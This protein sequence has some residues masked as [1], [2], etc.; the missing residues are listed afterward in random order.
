MSH[1][2]PDNCCN[3]FKLQTSQNLVTLINL[4]FRNKRRIY[5][6]YYGILK[7]RLIKPFVVYLNYKY[8]IAIF[9]GYS[10]CF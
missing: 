9:N 5:F 1:K 7:L 4:D 8:W 2:T 3:E 6:L 10:L